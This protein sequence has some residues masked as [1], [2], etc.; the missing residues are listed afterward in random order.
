[1]VRGGGA[2]CVVGGGGATWVVCGGAGGGGAAVDEAGVL[3]TEAWVVVGVTGRRGFGVVGVAVVSVGVGGAEETTLVP[4]AD[5]VRES[6]LPI[7]LLHPATSRI[8][9]SPTQIGICVRRERA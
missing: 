6:V 9:S 2:A 4:G 8:A 5:E 3:T 7:P 1:M